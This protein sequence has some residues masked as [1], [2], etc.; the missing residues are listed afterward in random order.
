MIA[1]L[2]YPKELK[3]IIHKLEA[4]D[5]LRRDPLNAFNKGIIV[6]ILPLLMLVSVSVQDGVVWLT[7]ALIILFAL[8]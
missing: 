6:V 8:T 2:F 3:D 7:L 5:N 1:E 4:E